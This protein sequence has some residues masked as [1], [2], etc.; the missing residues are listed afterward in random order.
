MIVLLPR[1]ANKF[2]DGS[3]QLATTGVKSFLVPG[4]VLRPLHH[5]SA[6]LSSP[7]GALATPPVSPGKAARLP[8]CLS[9]ETLL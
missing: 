3:K 5:T 8:A 9:H 7:W 4:E 6:R 2:R 1:T